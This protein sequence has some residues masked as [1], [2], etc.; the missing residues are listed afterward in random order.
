MIVPVD[1]AGEAA[2][3]QGLEVIPVEFLC[4]LVDFLNGAK[5]IPA[6]T[7]ELATAYDSARSYPVDFS[8]IQG[9][10]QAKRAMEVSAAG[11]HNIIMTGPPGSGKTMLAQRIPTILPE[12]SIEEALETTKIYSVVGA[13]GPARGDRGDK[14]LPRASSHDIRCGARGRR[15]HAETGGDQPGSQRGAVPRRAARVQAQRPRGVATAPRRRAGDDHALR[16]YRHLPGEVHARCG[17]E[18]LPLRVPGRCAKELPMQ[19]PADPAVPLEGVG[20]AAR[21]DR[22]PCGGA[23]AS[24]P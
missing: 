2:L 11:G 23:I 9:Q 22:H 18:P 6:V 19:R 3:V 16:D 8:E 14:A 21:P 17:D 4:D 15:A 13:A 7:C 10:E 1:N 12:L 24:L 20:A 5:D